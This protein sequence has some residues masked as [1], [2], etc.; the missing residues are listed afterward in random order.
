MELALIKSITAD[1]Q[2]KTVTSEDGPVPKL[3]QR[4]TTIIELT[5]LEN[6]DRVDLTNVGRVVANFR[7]KDKQV[8]S[9]LAKIEGGIVKYHVGAAEYETFGLATLEFEFYSVDDG[10]RIATIAFKIDV[11]ESIGVGVTSDDPEYSILQELFVEVDALK[12]GVDGVV[13]DALKQVEYAK[14]EGDYAKEQGDY[15]KAEADRL[16]GTDIGELTAQLADKANN[17]LQL[18]NKLL[19]GEV[20]KI[21]LIGDSVSAGAQCQGYNVPANGRVILTNSR[22]NEG[23]TG[24]AREAGTDW[25][26]F[27]SWANLFR[28]YIKTNYPNIDFF[29]AAITGL[30]LEEVMNDYLAQIVKD[31]EDVVFIMLGLNDRAES[32][33]L[34]ETRMRQFLDYVKSR[35]NLIILMS[36]PPTTSEYVDNEPSK[37]LIEDRFFGSREIDNTLRKLSE[38]Y[39]F[40]FVSHFISSSDYLS[41]TGKPFKGDDGINQDNTHPNTLGYK[42]MW[43]TIQNQL[44]F[45]NDVT[46]WAGNGY[47]ETKFLPFDSVKNSTPLSNFFAKSVTYCAITNLNTE[48]ASFPES[49][50]LLVTVKTEENMTYF[51][52]QQFYAYLTGKTYIRYWN[53]NNSTW[54]AWR[55]DAVQHVRYKYETVSASTPITSA[56]FDVENVTYHAIANAYASSFPEGTAGMLMTVKPL[57]ALSFLGYQ[58]YKTNNRVYLRTWNGSAWG[59]WKLITSNL[60]L[61][62]DERNTLATHID[63]GVCI[64]DKTLNKPVWRNTANNGWV[65]AT[66]TSV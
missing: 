13:A 5:V 22:F 20:T 64:F 66:G 39:N 27:P 3:H 55:H 29:N 58:Q 63:A 35:S 21:K 62:T 16:A 19:A 17:N 54:Q 49:R 8:I 46:E 18:L 40:P 36:P 4:D 26:T 33:E 60:A 59:F 24:Y 41:K 56:E 15:A 45:A 28:K 1:T 57:S 43:Q 48:S 32:L 9:R 31:D 38:E 2:K 12:S 50:G 52:Y 23:G 34:Y 47:K 30:A 65:D 6:G 61:T 7:R 10:S 14:T 42:V 51:S 11:S 37:G 44:H 53:S 25:N